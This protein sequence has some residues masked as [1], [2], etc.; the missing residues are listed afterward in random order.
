MTT[1]YPGF[2][3]DATGT[4]FTV[5]PAS[6][7]FGVTAGDSAVSPLVVVAAASRTV[8]EATRDTFFTSN[9]TNLATYDAA[10]N[11]GLGILLYF[12]SGSNTQLLAQTRVGSAWVDN[13][14]II[15]V[16]GATGQ[17]GNDGIDGTRLEFG[18]NTERDTFFASRL[19][20]LRV[21]LPIMVTVATET[22]SAQVWT[23]TTNPASY[24]AN[25]WRVASIRSGTASFELD[26]IHTFSSGGRQVFVT[27]EA[28]G[29][30]FFTA[31]QF[32]GDHSRSD[33]R[34]AS[35]LPLSRQYTGDLN[36]A[37]P[38]IE[39]GGVV[40]TSGSTPFNVDFDVENFNTSLFGLMYVPTEDYTGR[41]EYAV[42]ELD[43]GSNILVF[44]QT[45]DVTL[46]SGTPFIQWF[47]IPLELNDGDNVN[48]SLIKADASI[49]SVRP[50]AGNANRP[51][52]TSYLR[53]FTDEAVIVSSQGSSQLDPIIVAGNNITKT[54]DT[55]ANTITLAA[56]GTGVV[57]SEPIITSFS[58]Q[59]QSNSVS[60]DT[61]LSGQVT[62]NYN[63][64]RSGQVD[65]VLSITQDGTQIATNIVATGTST[66]AN[67]NEVTL[68]AGQSTTFII[69]GVSDNGNSFNRSLVIRAAQPHEFAYYGI[70]PTNDFSTVALA[71]LAS[72]DI[73]SND[74]F[75]VTGAFADTH[76]IGILAPA[77][78]DIT[79]IRTFGTNVLDT[80]D[81]AA[82]PVPRVINSEDYVLYTL[83][84]SGGIDGSAAYTVEVR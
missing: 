57:P 44:T 15:A 39:P 56:T 46:T 6:N 84:N 34:I 43:S 29:L 32:V 21:N 61:T 52:T 4:G 78:M 12:T 51:Y 14:T 62:F 8:A 3:G 22:V 17:N 67:I 1:G 81:R 10:G 77:S 60:P 28:S 18:S 36:A 26:E 59:G 13:N 7:L 55:V 33:R 63:V 68:A 50:E 37:P 65:G 49:L 24:D 25:F 76:F 27:N 47:R 23:G 45:I 82:S 30:S 83:Q 35:N 73:T 16:A 53:F 5:G 19:D 72:T 42:T 80:F 48:A 20:L 66:T 79:A 69:S 11:E 2:G 70:R 38:G 74:S 58:I 75:E 31:Q 40:A 71:S 64:M 54:V 41:L 9:P